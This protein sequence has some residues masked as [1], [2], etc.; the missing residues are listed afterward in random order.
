MLKN[1]SVARD[2]LL[3]GGGKVK[4]PCLKITQGGEEKWMYE[5][6]DIVSYLQQEFA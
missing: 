6:S 4:V 2:E 5:S 3:A 1:D